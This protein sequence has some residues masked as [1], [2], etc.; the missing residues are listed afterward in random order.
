MLETN[1][2]QDPLNEQLRQQYKTRRSK[3]EATQTYYARMVQDKQTKTPWT[4]GNDI[5]NNNNSEEKDII[6]KNETGNEIKQD[7]IIAKI[8]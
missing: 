4:A 1:Y 2:I 7:G 5:L 3:T 8:G 6:L